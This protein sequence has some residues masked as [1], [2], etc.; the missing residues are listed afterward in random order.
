MVEDAFGADLSTE[1]AAKEAVEGIRAAQLR[2]SK[3]ERKERQRKPAPPYITSRLQQE[4]SARYRFSA[5]PLPL[6]S[7]PR[8][9]PARQ[10][11]EAR[12]PR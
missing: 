8:R 4:A 6:L 10:G 11:P 5:P 1:D 7:P 3:V 2:V 9:A 12:Q